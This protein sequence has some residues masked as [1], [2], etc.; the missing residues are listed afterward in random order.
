MGAKLDCKRS[1]PKSEGAGME[2]R[3]KKIW[4]GKP[5]GPVKMVG[6]GL[7]EDT[8]DAALEAYF[9][10]FGKVTHI[11][12]FVWNDT[13]KKRGY[14]YIS[15]E[16][17]DVVDKIVLLGI[18]K[19]AGVSLY[20]KKALSK[21]QLPVKMDNTGRSM[22]GMGG[23]M[24]GM[25]GGMGGMGGMGGGMGGMGG[26]MGGMGG[27]GGGMGAGGMGSM[28]MGG[29]GGGMSGMGGH[30]MGS[31]SMG[32]AGG[33]G[34]NMMNP[35]MQPAQSMLQK[36]DMKNV[37]GTMGS[38]QTM[39]SQM[40]N[41]P[42]KNKMENMMSEMNS[43][44]GSMGGGGPKHAAAFP[45]G[46]GRFK[47][48]KGDDVQD[49]MMTMMNNMM[50]MMNNMAGMMHGSAGGSSA[51]EAAPAGGYGGTPAAGGYGT[52][53]AQAGGYGTNSG[54]YGYGTAA[55]TSGYDYSGGYS[56]AGGFGLGGFKK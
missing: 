30:G 36:P 23:G 48:E 38:F 28:G 25:G 47:E 32:G 19:V 11:H 29:M 33:G 21:E 34:N 20:A 22:G 6:P 41:T 35:M 39:I 43:M 37:M 51:G 44:I 24:S 55:A 40:G 42:A 8:T 49:K 50:S 3:V 17:E 5:E 27:M 45:P 15:F 14:G 46:A 56:A 2:E 7:N 18:H 9:G 1:T 12:Q 26:G 31:M 53:A 4:I 52:A 13:G 54:G 10:Q 16:D